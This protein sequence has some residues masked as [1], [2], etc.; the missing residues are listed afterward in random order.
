MAR[1]AITKVCTRTGFS[2]TGTPAKIA[3]H[4]YR[5]KSQKDGFSPWSKAA[6]RDYNKAYRAALKV[7]ESP[8]KGDASDEGVVAFDN[9]MQEAG[10]RTPRK[11]HQGEGA[12]KQDGTRTRQAKARTR[13]RKGARRAK[14]SA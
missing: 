12:N 10:V 2:V 11:S 6:E 13:A 4:F 1:K 7:A 5:D 9:T 8:R 14:A 3:E